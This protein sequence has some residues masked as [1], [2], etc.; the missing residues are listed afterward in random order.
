MKVLWG[1]L[2]EGSHILVKGPQRR[3][4]FSNTRAIET[5]TETIRLRPR[6]N[7]QELETQTEAKRDP[8]PDQMN[9]YSR[10]NHI[11]AFM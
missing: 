4:G 7:E 6:P 3:K 10:I 8:D 11:H 1:D 2:I 5:Q 9:K